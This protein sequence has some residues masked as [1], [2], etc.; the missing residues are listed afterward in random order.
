MISTNDLRR[1]SAIKLDGSIFVVL[2]AQHHK[3]GKGNTVVRTKMKSLEKGAI[4]ER[5][6]RAGEKVEEV[7]ID[8]RKMQFSFKEEGSY[9]FMD[10]ESFDQVHF[11]ADQI[12]DEASFLLENMEVEVEMVEDRPVNLIL[13]IFVTYELTECYPGLRGDTASGG[14]GTKR[15][16][17][18][19]GLIVNVPLFAEQ[20]D[21]VKV[22]TRTGEYIERVNK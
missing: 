5:T 18:Q 7:Y 4:I 22:D 16:T 6:L 17:C 10:L 21:L 13:P 8:R 9:V 20:G 11:P 12:T 15:A 1:G 3:P 14:G 2:E 19:N